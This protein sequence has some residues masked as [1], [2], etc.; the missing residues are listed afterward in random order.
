MM[1]TPINKTRDD[2][3]SATRYRA[4]MLWL[5]GAVVDA[6]LCVSLHEA[7]PH[8]GGIIFILAG[9]TVIAIWTLILG[10]GMAAD[11]RAW[12][13]V[14]SRSFIDDTAAPA[15]SPQSNTK[16][17]PTNTYEYKNQ[18]RANEYNQYEF[19]LGAGSLTIGLG[20]SQKQTNMATDRSGL[21]L[22]LIDMR[23]NE[24]IED[25]FVV[26]GAYLVVPLKHQGS[27]KVKLLGRQASS[28]QY[29]LSCQYDS[30]S[31]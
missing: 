22:Q 31:D 10:I 24:V 13:T 18:L 7:A 28:I 30:A 12:D 6:V 3:R 19:S 8:I 23:D 11:H 5:I 20:I 16:P 9:A 15:D 21:Q 14:L 2:I 27:Y 29:T 17:T 4:V 1:D 26:W 25:Q